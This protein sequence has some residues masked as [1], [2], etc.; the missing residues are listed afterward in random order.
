MPCIPFWTLG[1]R[2]V[3]RDCAGLPA[4]GRLQR[5]AITGHWRALD[6]HDVRREW[7]WGAT[8]AV[9]R[10]TAGHA[11]VLLAGI[12]RR[13][14]ALRGVAVA[15]RQ[16]RWKVWDHSY[17]TAT[18]SIGEHAAQLVERLRRAAPPQR[19]SFVTHSMGGLVAR[20][21]Q[22][23]LAADP[24][25]AWR[26]A[27]ARGR[28]CLLFAPNQGAAKARR[29]A[30]A[31]WYRLLFGPAGQ[32][33]VPLAAQR[34]PLPSQPCLMIAGATGCRRGRSRFVPGDDDGTVGVAETQLP[35]FPLL[36]FP[37]GH[38]R[39]MDDPAVIAAAIAWLSG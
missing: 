23:L 3:W 18:A 4:G 33:L 36:T 20:Q 15:C 26:E 27:V 6:Q 28:S 39:G 25:P 14:H 31:G 5:N 12:W 9:P 29:W 24:D 2:A 11:V 7:G 38:T 8:P 17:P 19:L 30:P 1:G 35:G 32:D 16:H 34:I 13:R 21:A 10:D 22:A 37:V